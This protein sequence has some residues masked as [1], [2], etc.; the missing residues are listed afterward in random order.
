MSQKRKR[1]PRFGDH[2]IFV[3][4]W[5]KGSWTEAMSTNSRLD[6]NFCGQ[7]DSGRGSWVE[8][9]SI[10]SKLDMSLGGWL[11]RREE[12]MRSPSTPID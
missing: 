11:D 7:L 12:L 10:Y 1:G 9:M 5:S 2:I 4:G 3:H 8:T 6:M